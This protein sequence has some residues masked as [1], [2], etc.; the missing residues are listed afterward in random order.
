VYSSCYRLH[1]VVFGDTGVTGFG[2]NVVASNLADGFPTSQSQGDL[3]S[4]FSVS[5]SGR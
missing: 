5:T 1:H 3:N 2:A 4:A